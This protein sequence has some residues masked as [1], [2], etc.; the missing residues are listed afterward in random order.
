MSEGPATV[1]ETVQ[2]WHDAVNARD[3]GAAVALCAP[4]VQVVGPK[5]TGSGH[6][7]MRA[8]L[9]RSGISLEPQHPLREVDGRVLVHEVAQW[10]TTAQA[11]AGAPTERPVD[12]WV[13]FAAAG[14]RLTSVARFETEA[15][16]LRAVAAPG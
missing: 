12:T 7:L 1:V 4:D 11:P 9:T 3:V 16:A 5:G 15:D 6:D 14:G 13:V 8:W 2:A 10:H